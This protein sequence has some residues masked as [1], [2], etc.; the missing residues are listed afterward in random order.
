M[1]A[2][3]ECKQCGQCCSHIR[4]LISL[5]DKNFL[6]DFAYGK[7]PIIS[8]VPIDKISFPLWDF[9]A[10]RFITESKRNH[11]NSKIVPSRAIYDLKNNQTI[12]VTYSIDSDSCTF[13]KDGR[14][15]IYGK[16]A[17][18]CRM[19][20]FQHTPFLK[21]GEKITKSEM[22]GACP[23]ISSILEKL[24]TGDIRASAQYL[25]E[26]FGNNFFAALQHDLVTEW[27]N[28]KIVE[29]IKNNMIKAAINYPYEFLLKRIKNSD[30]I[31]FTD[32]LVQKNIYSRGEM[33]KM[34]KGF[35]DFE[36]AKKKIALL[37]KR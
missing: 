34:I 24:N 9:E 17:F 7:L 6:K 30:K 18:I 23:N 15:A 35:E 31:D 33:D 32:L 29:L 3:F 13:L 25:K 16:R 36:G 26:S 2:K 27:A 20:P 21:T 22:F 1:A 14:C 19:F 11:I 12:I 28:K 8:L 10:K 4:G 5:A 37:D